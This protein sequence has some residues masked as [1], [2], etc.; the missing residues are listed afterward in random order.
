[1]A[2]T[3]PQ[4]RPLPGARRAKPVLGFRGTPGR[5]ALAVFRM[6][7]FLYRRGWGWML[8]RTFLL[9][10]HV[11]RKTGKPHAM[12]AQTLAYAP[13]TGEAVICSAWGPNSDWLR[14]VRARPALRVE[15][16]RESFAPV[17][18]FLTD[19]EAFE[20]AVEYRRR[21]PW[22]LRLE[23][24]IFGWD[25]LRSDAAVR[26]FVGERPFVS[27]RPASRSHA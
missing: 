3:S 13:D 8:G 17:Q 16:G 15:I 20:V 19:D 26:E 6:P 5:L 25:D 21:H 12:V 9:L 10:V 14:N 27:L 4:Q 1:M 2:L 23:A 22:R 11:G 7:L 24:L 18:R